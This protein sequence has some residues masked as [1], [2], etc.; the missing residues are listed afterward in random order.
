MPSI[1]SCKQEKQDFCPNG[2]YIIVEGWI[3]IIQTT[4]QYD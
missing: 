3:I 2:I 4:K 1:E